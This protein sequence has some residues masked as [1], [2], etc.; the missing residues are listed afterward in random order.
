M[1]AAPQALVP[2][3]ASKLPAAAYS[4]PPSAESQA[5]FQALRQQNESDNIKDE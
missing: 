4:A 2:A 1:P 5:R 3:Y